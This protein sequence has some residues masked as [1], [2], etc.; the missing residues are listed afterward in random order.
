MEN[1]KSS[2]RSALSK[3]LELTRAKQ[4]PAHYQLVLVYDSITPLGFITQ[5]LQD[6]FYVYSDEAAVMAVK[7]REFGEVVYGRF[8]REIAET[9]ISEVIEDARRFNYPLKCVMRKIG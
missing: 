7:L 8:T 3:K 5:C 1:H 9:K 6:H 2:L 4:K